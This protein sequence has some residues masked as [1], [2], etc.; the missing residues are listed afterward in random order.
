MNSGW[1]WKP[2]SFSISM[3]PS[4][5]FDARCSRARAMS[6][7]YWRQPEYPAQA[8]V[9]NTSARVTPSRAMSSTVSSII[10]CQLRLP[11][12]TGRSMPSSASFFSRLA[13]ISRLRSL[14]GER[15]PKW[16]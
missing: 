5:G 10:G 16:W 7:W 9:A 15:P 6:S 4:S 3:A 8:E 13:M 2:R 1:S 12:Y 11:K 14:S